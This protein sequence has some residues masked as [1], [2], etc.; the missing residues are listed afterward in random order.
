MNHC[1]EAVLG[2]RI[3]G[4]GGGTEVVDESSIEKTYASGCVVARRACGRAP[5]DCSKVYRIGEADVE[6]AEK[7]GR[8]IRNALW[9]EPGIADRTDHSTANLEIRPQANTRGNKADAQGDVRRG[10]AV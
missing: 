5:L 7:L 10:A 6:A 8:P 9:S 2:F 4:P 3:G 1:V